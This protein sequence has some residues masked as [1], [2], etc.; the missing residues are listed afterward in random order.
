MEEITPH[1]RLET[2]LV[3][4][5]AC[6]TMS[7]GM[8]GVSSCFLPWSGEGAE[9]LLLLRRAEG[10]TEVPGSQLC[11]QVDIC[12]QRSPLR[13][14]DGPKLEQ[15]KRCRHRDTAP[16]FVHP[17]QNIFLVVSGNL[18]GCIWCLYICP[19]PGPLTGDPDSGNSNLQPPTG[20]LLTAV[21][22]PSFLPW[23]DNPSA[24][25]FPQGTEAAWFKGHHCRC[26]W[27]WHS[28]ESPYQG[29]TT[30]VPVLL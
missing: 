13:C 2:V 14:K 1:I 15:G 22:L 6:S 26:H 28:G 17:L 20:Q 4:G 12:P 27:H 18:S 25:C 16:D 29:E 7:G 3:P 11:T 9:P 5:H 10:L 24:L 21:S 19:V 30:P 23:A 8:A